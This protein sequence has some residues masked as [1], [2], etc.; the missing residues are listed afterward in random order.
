MR[1]AQAVHVHV[2]INDYV[3]VHVDVHVIVDVDVDGFGC[4]CAAPGKSVSY[5]GYRKQATFSLFETE[6]SLGYSHRQRSITSEQR[7]WK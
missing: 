2:H 4:G 7:G 3:N 6:M 1:M 5:C